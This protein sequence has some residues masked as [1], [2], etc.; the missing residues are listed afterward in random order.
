MDA[1]YTA[2]AAARLRVEQWAQRRTALAERRD[3][4]VFQHEEL[5]VAAIAVGE[6]DALAQERERLRHAE[7]L[8]QACHDGEALLYSGHSA[9]VSTLGRLGHQ[10]AELGAI[11]P[12]LAASAE[13][14]ENGRVQLE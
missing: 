4:L 3:L 14:V 7:R 8:R 13:L 10:L 1:A 6:A 11:A 5:Q 9:M 12:A 2:F